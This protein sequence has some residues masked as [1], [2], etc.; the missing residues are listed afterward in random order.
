MFEIISLVA[1]VLNFIGAI[2]LSAGLIKSTDQI[3]DES[4]TYYGANPYT[5]NSSLKSQPYYK[6][7]FRIFVTG[8]AINIALG[9]RS[10]FQFKDERTTT[11]ILAFGLAIFGIYLI[12]VFENYGMRAHKNYKLRLATDSFFNQLRQF[13][14]QT[15][16]LMTKYDLPE[17]EFTAHKTQ[18]VSYI[19]ETK[20][21]LDESYWSDI[22]TLLYNLNSSSDLSSFQVVFEDFLKS[23]NLV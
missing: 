16:T 6:V 22:D 14:T 4:A 20:S 5:S 10:I 17:N 9:L 15:K 21:S 12:Q 23:R 19:Q 2:F 3:K 8:F 13:F 11:I 7:G 1:N 18:V